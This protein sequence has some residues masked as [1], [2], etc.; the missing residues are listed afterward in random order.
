MLA[1]IDCELAYDVYNIMYTYFLLRK[2]TMR[3]RI[4]NRLKEKTQASG[5][6]MEAIRNTFYLIL[7]QKYIE[8]LARSFFI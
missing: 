6:S 7:M 2:M 1:L 5:N 4:N 8:K 3:H